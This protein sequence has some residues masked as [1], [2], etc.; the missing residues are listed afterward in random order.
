[1]RYFATLILVSLITACAVK[2][3]QQFKYKLSDYGI[4]PQTKHVGKT[5]LLV[6]TPLAA[7][8]Y[9]SEQML[10]IQKPFE[11]GAFSKNAWVAS[12][13]RMLV[14]LIVQS[15]QKSKF[16]FAVTSIPYSDKTQYRLDTQLI[17][18]QQNFLT[19]P[20]T[21]ELVIKNVL[22]NAN[23]N[24]VMASNLFSY[25]VPCPIEGPYGGV[26]AAN[27]ATKQYTKDL[28]R[29]VIGGIQRSGQRHTSTKSSSASSTY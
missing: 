23:T 10:Y 13:A 22:T 24:Q 1:M 7:S 27:V 11:I 15:L 17:E 5:S 19:T 12:P 18:M 28:T 25:K 20:S 14:P 9:D 4:V 3:P 26:M 21:L 29:F 16:F 8:G 6:S 2:P